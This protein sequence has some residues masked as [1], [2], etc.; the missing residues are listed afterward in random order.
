MAA[1]DYYNTSH[2]QPHGAPTQYGNSGSPLSPLPSNQNPYASSP[3]DDHDYY[4]TPNSSGALGGLP[5][6]GNTSYQ[7]AG[8]QDPFTDHNAIPLHAQPKM[9]GH[10]RKHDDSSPIRYPVDEE[11]GVRRRR[12][13]RKKKKG[14]FQGRVTWVCYI[15]TIVQVGVFV[16]ELIKNGEFACT[17]LAVVRLPRSW[18]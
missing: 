1:N 7:G 8:Q 6:H 15:L 4:N 11:G 2:S 16:G 3:F 5:P 12:S 13:S 14:W 10:G 17:I 18:T 9:D